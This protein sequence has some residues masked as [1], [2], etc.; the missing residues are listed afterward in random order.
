MAVCLYDIIHY[1]IITD[2]LCNVDYLDI[3][4]N[5]S[6]KVGKKSSGLC[7][8]L[9]SNSEVKFPLFPPES[10]RICLYFKTPL[11]CSICMSKSK[12]KINKGLFGITYLV[13]KYQARVISEEIHN[14]SY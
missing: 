8:F 9:F 2:V 7:T 14:V 12:K 3:Y 10:G 1:H 6:V 4:A 13:S 5:K 11:K